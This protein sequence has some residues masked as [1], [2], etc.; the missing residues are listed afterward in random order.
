MDQF[1]L[2]L[3]DIEE[4]RRISGGDDDGGASGGTIAAAIAIPVFACILFALCYVYRDEIQE[5]FSSDDDPSTF[6]SNKTVQKNTYPSKPKYP[7]SSRQPQVYN[8][9][10]KPPA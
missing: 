3:G 8:Q 2:L 6:G 1:Q 10:P 4:A 7:V 5:K 9:A